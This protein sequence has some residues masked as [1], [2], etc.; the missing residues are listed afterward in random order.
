MQTVWPNFYRN[1]TVSV[2]PYVKATAAAQQVNFSVSQYYIYECSSQ[3][4]GEIYQHSFC[5]WLYHKQL[6]STWANKW[7]ILRWWKVPS[8]CRKMN[9]M[10]QVIFGLL[11]ERGRQPAKRTRTSDILNISVFRTSA[12]ESFLHHRLHIAWRL[13]SVTCDLL[14][15]MHWIL[16]SNRGIFLNQVH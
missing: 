9:C 4:L 7:K 1:N 8:K 14:I 16:C 2:R 6:P 15:H 5:W 11:L 10:E 3:R 13:V 12:W